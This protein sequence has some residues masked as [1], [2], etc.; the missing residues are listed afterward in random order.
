MNAPMRLTASGHF[1]FLQLV[2]QQ[3]SHGRTAQ[4]PRGAAACQDG[5]ADSA[6]TRPNRG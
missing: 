6:G 4:S 2:S 3:A 1:L 5:T